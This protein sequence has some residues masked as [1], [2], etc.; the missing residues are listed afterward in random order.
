MAVDWVQMATAVGTSVIVPLIGAKVLKLATPFNFLLSMMVANTATHQ[1]WPLLHPLER[2]GS[3]Y[4]IAVG[5][6]LIV[7]AFVCVGSVAVF[8]RPEAH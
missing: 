8:R 7:T 3:T 6:Y 4:A 5:M 2:Q 1:I